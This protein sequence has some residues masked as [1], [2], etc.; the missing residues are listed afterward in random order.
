M[1]APCLDCPDRRVDCHA[2]CERYRSYQ[3]VREAERQRRAVETI[4]QCAQFDHSCRMARLY[5]AVRAAPTRR[6]NP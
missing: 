4:L 5:P 1:N 2:F 3:L 6:R